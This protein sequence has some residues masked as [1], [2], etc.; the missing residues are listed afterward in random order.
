MF[1]ANENSCYNRYVK[2]YFW[3][4]KNLNSF[5][6]CFYVVLIAEKWLKMREVPM[7]S[8]WTTEIPM[9]QNSLAT[10]KTTSI[11]KCQFVGK[12]FWFLASK[13]SE[14]QSSELCEKEKKKYFSYHWYWYTY[15]F[16]TEFIYCVI[17]PSIQWCGLNEWKEIWY[18]K[19]SEWS[20]LYLQQ[21]CIKTRKVE[22][23]QS[24][25]TY[26]F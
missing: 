7:L 3:Y 11:P 4:W 8:G 21:F 26:T 14:I 18:Q 2:S 10:R 16:H 15:I 9:T 24:K 23:T 17:L 22:T 20:L 19:V 6:H 1:S 5:L 13:F 12:W 25:I